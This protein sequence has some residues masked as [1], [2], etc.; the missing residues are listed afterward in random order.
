MSFANFWF[1]HMLVIIISF[2]VLFSLNLLKL[3]LILPYLEILVVFFL[4]E[5]ACIS[6]TN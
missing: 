5:Y 4:F 6:P 1:I 2:T 3:Y